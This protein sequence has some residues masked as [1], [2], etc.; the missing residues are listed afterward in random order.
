M[1][2][3]FFKSRNGKIPLPIFF[4]DATRAVIRSIDTTDLIGTKTKG[5]L[6]NTF[7]LWQGLGSDVVKKF[8]GIGL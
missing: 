3:K 6:V 7:H 4:P 2:K 5:I 8:E 1:T